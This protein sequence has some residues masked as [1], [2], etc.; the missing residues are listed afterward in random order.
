[1]LTRSSSIC[2]LEGDEEDGER[3]EEEEPV[4]DLLKAGHLTRL[5]EEDLSAE[6]DALSLGGVSGDL[7]SLLGRLRT[8]RDACQPQQLQVGH[9]HTE[10]LVY[11][12]RHTHTETLVYGDRHTH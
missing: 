1:M 12:D 8:Q 9:T 4:E 10:T 7:S 5:L 11:G 3:E 6:V 2:T